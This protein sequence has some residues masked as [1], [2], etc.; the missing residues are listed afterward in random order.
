MTIRQP[1]QQPVQ[2][3]D[4]TKRDVRTQFGAVCWRV[5]DG[6]V[7]ILLITSR[8]SGR[9]IIPK[10]WPM[11]QA[12]PAEAAQT[13]AW[14]EAG[15]EGKVAPVC[16]GIFS[17]SKEL[18]PGEALPCVVAV[19][20]VKVKELKK[21]YPERTARRRKWFSPRKAAKLVDEPELATMIKNFDPKAL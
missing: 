20:P 10:G 15:V 1:K 17:Y 3:E 16:L 4:V 13:E 21:N 12:T 18:D 14:E 9:W 2:L 11:D 5:K 8:G 19:F 6:D 7:Q